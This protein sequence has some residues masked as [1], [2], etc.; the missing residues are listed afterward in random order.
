MSNGLQI[1]FDNFYL[2]LHLSR[3][4]KILAHDD[5]AALKIDL[6]F[7]QLLLSHMSYMDCC[8]VEP[9]ECDDELI[10]DGLDGR[11]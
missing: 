9:N 10:V 1:V 5:K 2:V 3:D 4:D 6:P 11:L 7:V 8:G